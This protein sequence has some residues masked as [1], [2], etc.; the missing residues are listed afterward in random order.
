MSPAPAPLP[1][2]APTEAYVPASGAMFAGGKLRDAL[3]ALDR[4]PVGDR[5][6]AGAPA[7]RY[8]A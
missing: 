8:S 6:R 7:R 1:V 4:V 3:R 2:P 5:L